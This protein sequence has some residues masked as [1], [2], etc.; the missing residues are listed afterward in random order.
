MNVI[1]FPLKKLL[2]VDLIEMTESES[3]AYFGGQSCAMNAMLARDETDEDI[4][5]GQYAKSVLRALQCEASTENWLFLCGLMSHLLTPRDD[6][7]AYG[8]ANQ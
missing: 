4:A 2:S 3:T 5:A 1:N 7:D 6:C 8:R